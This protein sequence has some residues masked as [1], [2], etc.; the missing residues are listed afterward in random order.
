[1]KYPSVEDFGKVNCACLKK[2]LSAN[3][4]GLLLFPALMM[5]QAAPYGFFETLLR[6]RDSMSKLV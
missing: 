5:W 1:L 2:N 3:V 6:E 4:G